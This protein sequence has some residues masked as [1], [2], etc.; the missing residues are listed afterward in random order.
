MLFDSHAHFDDSKFDMKDEAGNTLRDTLI[1]RALNDDGVK[2]IIN[3][4]VSA[5]TGNT[6]ISLAEKHPRFYATAGI[7]PKNWRKRRKT[8]QIHLK[9]LEFSFLIRKCVYSEKSALIII[10]IQTE[11]C[12]RSGLSFK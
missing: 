11:I 5:E 8:L 12:R 1:S 9:S 3:A 6:A 10:M 7:H 4:A 2:C